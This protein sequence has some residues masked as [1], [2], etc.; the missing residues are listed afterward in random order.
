MV[1]RNKKLKPW[2]F[3]ARYEYNQMQQLAYQIQNQLLQVHSNGLNGV[4]NPYL[5]RK[6]LPE[7][8][9]A[10]ANVRALCAAYDT[11]RNRRSAYWANNAVAEI[12]LLA[13]AIQTEA[14]AADRAFCA[15]IRNIYQVRHSVK[16]ALSLVPDILLQLNAGPPPAKP[17]TILDEVDQII[18]NAW[19]DDTQ[20]QAS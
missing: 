11:K 12:D 9:N 5:V 7:I 13:S 20:G 19:D 17:E 3:E 10:A 6:L 14:E 18:Q 8:A 4:R 1:R 2:P 16:A 15:K